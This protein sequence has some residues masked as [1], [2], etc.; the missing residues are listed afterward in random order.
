M[1]ISPIDK[2]DA[3]FAELSAPTETKGE[4]FSLGDFV[5]PPGDLPGSGAGSGS[6]PGPGSA[7]RD[8]NDPIPEPEPVEP[9]PPAPVIN[10]REQAKLLI[11][12]VDGFQVLS[13][14]VAYQRSFFTKAELED[15]KD[16][17]RRLEE[18]RDKSET[19]LTV[20]DQELLSRYHDCQELIEK[21][22][23][24][25]KEVNMLTGPMAAVMEKYN[26]TPG[27]ETLLMGA[28]FTVMG[29]RL[30]PLLVNINK[31]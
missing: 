17:K 22:P 10:F 9:T 25:D 18:Q 6:G 27:P 31:F 11:A 4:A 29:P 26:F 3:L 14:P 24:T 5:N 2:N 19:V 7:K 20:G 21:L 28:L 30:A 8:F 1:N 12:F 15:L 16:L 23:F 13:L